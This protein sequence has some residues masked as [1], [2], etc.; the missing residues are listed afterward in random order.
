MNMRN[1]TYNNL[2]FTLVTL[3]MEFIHQTLLSFRKVKTQQEFPQKI[4]LLVFSPVMYIRL[5]R[6]DNICHHNAQCNKI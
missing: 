3:G 5:N 1:I 2:H 4:Y 6:T